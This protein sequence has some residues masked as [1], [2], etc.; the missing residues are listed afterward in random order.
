MN[1]LENA[2]KYRKLESER[3]KSWFLDNSTIIALFF[4]LLSLFGAFTILD[5]TKFHA[6]NLEKVLIGIGVAALWILYISIWFIEGTKFEK[7]RAL[8]QRNLGS[9]LVE[10]KEEISKIPKSKIVLEKVKRLGN[11]TTRF[12]LVDKEGLIPLELYFL[13]PDGEIRTIEGQFP[14]KINNEL[15]QPILEASHFN[16]ELNLHKIKK[17]YYNGVVTVSS[18]EEIC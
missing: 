1:I 7:S 11:A 13:T 16:V 18:L 12:Q 5:L 15:K 10:I 2:E 8:N 9:T 3:Y 4:L 17:G 6:N 14:V